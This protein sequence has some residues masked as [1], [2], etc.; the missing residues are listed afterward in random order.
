MK[1]GR[2]PAAVV[3][4]RAASDPTEIADGNSARAGSRVRRTFRLPGACSELQK[5]HNT[6]LAE[7]SNPPLLHFHTGSNEPAKGNSINLRT[8]F[9]CCA[10]SRSAR[11]QLRSYLA[12]GVC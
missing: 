9:L 10:P 8:I 4:V 6:R 11:Q 2:R 12:A 1:H 3:P 7:S 5:A